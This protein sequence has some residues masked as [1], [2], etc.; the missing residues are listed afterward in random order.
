MNYKPS[1]IENPT[2]QSPS[3]FLSPILNTLAYG[4]SDLKAKLSMTWITSYYMKKMQK[5]KHR[6]WGVLFFCL[7]RV[8]PREHAG[9]QARGRIRAAAVTPTPTAHSDDRSLTH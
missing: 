1:F 4:F 3:L 9:S 6:F 7:F 8:A 2:I 5:M